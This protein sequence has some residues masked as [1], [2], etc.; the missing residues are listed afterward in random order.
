MR[1]LVLLG[2]VIL[3]PVFPAFAVMPVPAELAEGTEPHLRVLSADEDGA[4]IVFDLPELVIQEL[5][6][7]GEE[8]Q[9]L[10]IP[11]GGFA[12]ESGEPALPTYSRL[13]AVPEGKEIR[14]HL[15]NQLFGELVVLEIHVTISCPLQIL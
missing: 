1:C 11:G 15:L 2:L 7:E 10:S 9:V 3:V 14:V 5:V 13:V 6:R 8:F 4:T 12:G